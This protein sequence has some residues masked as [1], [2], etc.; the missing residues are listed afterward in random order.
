MDPQHCMQAFLMVVIM[1]TGNYNF[2]NFLYMALCLSLADN[3]WLGMVRFLS[4]LRIRDI[5]VWIRIRRSVPLTNGSRSFYFSSVTFK[6]PKEYQLF[7]RKLFSL[8]LFE[9]IHLRHFFKRLKVIKKSRNC[10]IEV[11]L[12][13]TVF[14]LSTY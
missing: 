13:T 3:S 5:L 7:F 4:V 1:L 6:T 8:L 14:L 11:F 2:F 12:T 10:R 9:G